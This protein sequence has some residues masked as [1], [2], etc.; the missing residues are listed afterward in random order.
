MLLASS[1]S[2]TLADQPTLADHTHLGVSGSAGWLGI[3][4]LNLFI[5]RISDSGRGFRDDVLNAI[6][7]I[8]TV[9][10]LCCHCWTLHSSQSFWPS[11]LK[12]FW[13]CT[14]RSGHAR[15]ISLRKEKTWYAHRQQRTCDTKADTNKKLPKRRVSSISLTL[16]NM[17]QK[18]HQLINS[19]TDEPWHKQQPT[20]DS[21]ETKL[22]AGSWPFFLHKMSLVV[23]HLL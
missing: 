22:N 10:T 7:V 17:T 14:F 12:I 6:I 19:S 1:A 16:R 23:P 9:S 8:A 13:F 21:W 4:R 20:V 18:Q 11:T 3:S 2:P 15:T 5:G